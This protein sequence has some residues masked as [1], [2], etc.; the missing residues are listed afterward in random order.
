MGR[1]RKYRDSPAIPKTDRPPARKQEVSA[2]GTF[3]IATALVWVTLAILLAF[4]LATFF[5]P[6]V[7]AFYRL[8]INYN[9]GWNVYNTQAAME[10]RPLYPLK[11]GWTTVNY[12]FLSFYLVGYASRFIG[13]YLLTGRLISLVA[14]LLSCILVGLIIKKLTGGWGPAVF[15]GA[16]CV[17]LFCSRFPDYVG[18][19]DPQMLAHPFFLFGL[20][21]YMGDPPST[22]RLAG[23][24]SVFALGGNIKHNLFPAPI[25]VL[26]DLLLT[27]A[28]K[29]VRFVVFG[30]VFLV[31]SI[32]INMLVGGPFFVSN[33]LAPR[34]YSLVKIR[35][36]F[37]TLYPPLG[38][39]LAISAFWSI[40]QL[41]NRQTWVISF[42]FFWSLLIG[43]AFVGGAGVNANTFFD[44][45]FAMSII[46]GACLDSLWKAPIP[47][48]GRG[49]P[50]RFLVP[51]LLYSTVIM[52]FVLAGVRIP[53]S[54]SELQELERQFD[55]EVSFLVAQPG[56]AICESLTLCYEAGK[57]YVL[58]PFNS[59]RLVR[60][61]KLNSN[62]LAK[63][64]AEK[65]FG[66]IQTYHP[67][68]QRPNSGFPVDVLD[69]MDRYY[70]EAFKGHE[71]YFY[72]PRP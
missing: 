58:D 8:E 40:W 46:M 1:S 11:Y 13:D 47:N 4:S 29:A 63:Q 34:A 30:V 55:A 61:G 60:L 49:S 72:L 32:A 6:T 70:V 26:C 33:L 52:M 54:L 56:P 36:V 10:H 59:T 68:N 42:Y 12:P 25:A 19:D 44:N 27:S 62:D 2:E 64:I 31:L 14:F 5:L 39:P 57:P 18:M 48:L 67:V 71:G 51:V 22:L 35:T 16:F 17:G 7:R 37:F 53:E 3:S 41:R 23:I 20:W 15:G 21:L 38:L 9:E 28:S 69:A 24:T 50:G 43:A 45:F 65:K 66:A